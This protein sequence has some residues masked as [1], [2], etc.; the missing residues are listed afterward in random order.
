MIKYCRCKNCKN[1]REKHQKN[2]TYKQFM[3]ESKIIEKTGI[4]EHWQWA[5][6]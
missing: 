5:G 6:K 2:G 1:I 3:R 4:S